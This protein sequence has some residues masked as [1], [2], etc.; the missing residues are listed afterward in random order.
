MLGVQLSYTHIETV[1]ADTNEHK[2]KSTIIDAFTTGLATYSIKGGIGSGL[3]TSEKQTNQIMEQQSAITYEATGRNTLLGQNLS[4]W[5]LSVED[6]QRC[7]IIEYGELLPVYKLLNSELRKKIYE[8][9]RFRSKK[10]LL[11]YFYAY[12]RHFLSREKVTYENIIE[13]T[14]K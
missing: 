7:R 4:E 13:K 5:C 14:D 6:N 2:H 10:F 12:L 8:I 3:S 9:I 1:R 11:V